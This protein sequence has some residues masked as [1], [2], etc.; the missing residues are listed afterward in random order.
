MYVKDR[1]IGDGRWEM[2]DGRWEMGDGRWRERSEALKSERSGV[3][4]GR[5]E[6]ACPA[7][8]R[9]TCCRGDRRGSVE[10]EGKR[11]EGRGKREC[12]VRKA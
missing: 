6:M 4:Q 11:E 10:C 7:A 1:R 8:G 2:G 12:G 9:R 5:S 3:L